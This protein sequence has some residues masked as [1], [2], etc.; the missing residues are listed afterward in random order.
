MGTMRA[1]MWDIPPDIAVWRERTGADRWDEVWD[2]VLHMSP[3]PIDE[4]QH[5]ERALLV[6]LTEHWRRQGRGEVMH[7]RSVA[8]PGLAEWR[9]DYRVPDI[10]LL[11]PDRFGIERKAYLEGGPTVA[12]EIHTPGDESYDK[13]PF[14]FEVGTT[15]A[16]ILHRDTKVPELFVRGPDAFVAVPA[17]PDGWLRS[18]ATDIELRALPPA[19][20]AFRLVG[21]PTTERALPED[22]LPSAAG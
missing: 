22:R 17:D 16:W 11:R 15:E 10:V 14:H 4:H 8:R 18:P 21:Q 20:V 13:L 9:R 2:G 6:W 19:K 1:V 7:Q 12:I 5:V 3:N